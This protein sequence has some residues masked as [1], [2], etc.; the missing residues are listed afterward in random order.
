M[1]PVTGEGGGGWRRVDD[2]RHLLSLL[3]MLM[4]RGEGVDSLERS[5]LWRGV[6]RR[7]E[8]WSGVEEA[9]RGSCCSGRGWEGGGGL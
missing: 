3:S 6:A 7:G 5:R 4:G 9:R 2:L 1:G 8:A